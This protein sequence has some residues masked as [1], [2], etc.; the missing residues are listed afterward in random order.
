MGE[1]DDAGLRAPRERQ[2]DGAARNPRRFVGSMHS[3]DE[4]ALQAES[5]PRTFWW[6]RMQEDSNREGAASREG[7]SRNRQL[8][9]NTTNH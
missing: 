1:R 2:V 4:E 3:S 6:E 8:A 5:I 7:L 9:N